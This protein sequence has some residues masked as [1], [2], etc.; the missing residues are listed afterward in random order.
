[1]WRTMQLITEPVRETHK[2]AVLPLSRVTDPVLCAV[3]HRWNQARDG[4]PM[5]FRSDVN[6]ARF[7]PANGFV[8]IANHEPLMGEFR[9]TLFGTK[10]AA[11]LG[12]DYTGKLITEMRPRPFAALAREHYHRVRDTGAPSLH[13]LVVGSREGD[14][15]FLRLLLPLTNEGYGVDSV[16]AVAARIPECPADSGADLGLAIVKLPCGLRGACLHRRAVISDGSV[17]PSVFERRVNGSWR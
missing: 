16:I 3:F 1:M 5:A 17:F 6:P 10:L 11:E 2:S 9:Y 7:R 13:C 14:L 8:A 12:V 15:R 4:R